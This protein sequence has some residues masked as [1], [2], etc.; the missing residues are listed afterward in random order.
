MI[1]TI[2]LLQDTVM[3]EVVR[4]R[5]SR[6]QKKNEMVLKNLDQKKILASVL[7]VLC[8]HFSVLLLLDSSRHQL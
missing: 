7:T 5:M 8:G 4:V 1:K 6:N 2:Y 3:L